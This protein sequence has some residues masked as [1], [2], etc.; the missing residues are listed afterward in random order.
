VK[1]EGGVVLT[2]GTA[3]GITRS[4]VDAALAAIGRGCVG[5]VDDSA[6]KCKLAALCEA[7]GDTS[8]RGRPED[9]DSFIR[10]SAASRFARMRSRCS[11]VSCGTGI[12]MARPGVALL[13]V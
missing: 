6:A 12:S 8:T 10:S 5:G 9:E 1:S 3:S 2:D 11:G 4:R 7:D 13:L